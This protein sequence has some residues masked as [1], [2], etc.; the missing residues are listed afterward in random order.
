MG[1]GFNN[2]FYPIVPHKSVLTYEDPESEYGEKCVSHL[3]FKEFFQKVYCVSL[4][5][6][7]YSGFCTVKYNHR[8]SK[9]NQISL[10]CIVLEE[11][12]QC[13]ISLVQKDAK[14]YYL[15]DYKYIWV[16]VIVV[17]KESEKNYRWIAGRY[18]NTKYTNISLSL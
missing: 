2:K 13:V 7:F 4:H 1:K 8:T 17:M 14:H 10:R 6:Y 11:S 5:R 15:G 16:R 3:E 12:T 18:V 9:S